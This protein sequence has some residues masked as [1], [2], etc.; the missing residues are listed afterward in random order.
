[1]LSWPKGRPAPGPV[2]ATV[3]RIDLP[4]GQLYRM[5]QTNLFDRGHFGYVPVTMIR[6]EDQIF[7]DCDHTPMRTVAL[8]GQA[9]AAAEFYIEVEHDPGIEPDR[10]KDST[11]YDPAARIFA[12]R[13]ALDRSGTGL[14][15][16]VLELPAINPN[17]TDTCTD[18]AADFAAVLQPSRAARRA[19]VLARAAR[20]AATFT[21]AL[22]N[23]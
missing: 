9:Y 19:A 12:R 18:A 16:V 13:P 8:A 2:T 21:K 11:Y 20:R 23:R 3:Q 22:T 7:P 6:T 17:S 15:T 5:R 4:D 14:R 1:M 10:V